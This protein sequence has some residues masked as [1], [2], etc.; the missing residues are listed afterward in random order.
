MEGWCQHFYSQGNTSA[1]ATAAQGKRTK[2]NAH[3]FCLQNN[4]SDFHPN[5]S[6]TETSTIYTYFKP[7][8]VTRKLS[9]ELKTVMIRVKCEGLC[10]KSVNI[11][12]KPD[13]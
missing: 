13:F 8:L 5:E 2:K 4:A 3:W 11:Q 7:L 6:V 1:Y 10:L 9:L 12:W